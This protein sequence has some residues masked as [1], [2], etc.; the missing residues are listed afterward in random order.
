MRVILVGAGNVAY[1]L[2]YALRNAGHDLVQIL[3]RNRVH[4]ESLAHELKVS[5][6][7]DCSE[8][9]AECDIIILCVSDSALAYVAKGITDVLNAR[10]NVQASTRPLILHTAG[11]MALDTIPYVRRGVLYPMQSFTKG[12][13]ADFTHLPLFIETDTVEDK[14]EL[15]SFALSLSDQVFPL[16][17]E[18]RRYL[19]LSAVFCC[20]FANHCMTMGADVLEKHNIP[21]KVMLP[22]IEGMTKKLHSLPPQKAQTGPAVRSDNNVMAAQHRLL[23]A[24][25]REDL[26]F[27]YETLSS[28]IQK[29]RDYD[30]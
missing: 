21:F 6:F 16:S 7:S 28:S 19:H 9:L 17:S 14:K 29:Y 10:M 8:N 18:G 5:Q 25:K 11:S 30:K 4:A 12:Y 23:C 2:G 27:M 20:N 1:S 15:E 26:A 13:L 24:D 3:S 22:L